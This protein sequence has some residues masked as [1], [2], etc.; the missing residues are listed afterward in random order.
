VKHLSQEQI[1]ALVTRLGPELDESA[2]QHLAVCVECAGRLAREAQ[3]ESDLYDVAATASEDAVVA[4]RRPGLGRMW[5]IALPAAAA[6]VVV[7][8]GVRFLLPRGGPK[9]VPLS[10]HASS[11]LPQQAP[12]LEDPC[13]VGP[14]ACVLPPEDVCRYATVERSRHPAF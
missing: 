2:R 10:L 5:R 11:P 1:E 8:L 6:L 9:Q 3:F 7:V 4:R 12:N 14:G 13:S